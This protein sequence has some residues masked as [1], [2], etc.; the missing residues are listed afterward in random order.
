M[1]IIIGATTGLVAVATW[2]D[3]PRVERSVALPGLIRTFKMVNHGNNF[4]ISRPLGSLLLVL[5]IRE[6]LFHP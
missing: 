4:S 2:Y 5:V 6:A 1:K 3:V